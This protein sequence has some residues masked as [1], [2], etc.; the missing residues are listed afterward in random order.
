MSISLQERLDNV[1]AQ[2]VEVRDFLMRLCGAEQ[3]LQDLINDQAKPEVIVTSGDP[4]E[5]AG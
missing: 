1:R 5:T 3:A 4:E 2:K